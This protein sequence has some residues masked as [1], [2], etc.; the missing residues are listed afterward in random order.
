MTRSRVQDL[1]E[2][3]PAK[4]SRTLSPGLGYILVPLAPL[5]LF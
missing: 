1:L 5:S 3:Y 2:G 4:P